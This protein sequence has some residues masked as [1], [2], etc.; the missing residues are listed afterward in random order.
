MTKLSLPG[1]IV[2]PEFARY[3]D[4]DVILAQFGQG[5]W[6]SFRAL[7]IDL[8][9]LKAISAE[10]GRQLESVEHPWLCWN[11][12]ED[13]CLVQQKLVTEAGWTP[14]VGF[15][16]RVGPPGRSLP[17]AVVF[18]FNADLG[19]PILY[20]HFALEFAF[21]FCARI[22]FWHS[23][24][25]IRREK[26]AGLGRIFRAL[27]DGQTAAT[28]VEPGLR[29]AFSERHK[30]YWE[31]VGCTTRGASR[32]QFE[33]GCGWWMA[34]WAH[35]NQTDADRIK[36][37]YY[38]DHGAGIYYW[39]KRAHGDVVVIPGKDYEE[40]HFTKIGNKDYV[41]TRE[42]GGTDARRKMSEE[43]VRYFD[44]DQ[45]CTKLGLTDMLAG[46]EAG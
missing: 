43:I 32:D 12:N 36:R 6:Q 4:Y 41:R 46:P 9:E 38:W 42:P 1:K 5:N 37:K 33:K 22:A 26:M 15:D 27:K 39:D 11:V 28:W 20:P 23:D 3:T 45:A 34:Y 18:D 2:K 21:Q 40:G 19:L 13:W 30:R 31:L 24:L 10:W 16:P 8:A 25:L 14:L 17:N 29:H 35:P 7:D 44:F